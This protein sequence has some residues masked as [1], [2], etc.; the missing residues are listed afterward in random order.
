MWWKFGAAKYLAI[1]TWFIEL[2]RKRGSNG[3]FYCCKG[4]IPFSGIVIEGI[5]KVFMVSIGTL[6]LKFMHVICQ[7]FISASSFVYNSNC[8]LTASTVC[9]KSYT[10]VYFYLLR[11][12]MTIVQWFPNFFS[13]WHTRKI[14]KCLRHAYKRKKVALKKLFSR[15]NEVAITL[16]NRQCHNWFHRHMS[17]LI[18]YWSN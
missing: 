11:L 12:F 6:F 5:I 13:L 10:N 7:N 8:K 16:F 4:R 15:I 18:S 3:V 17:L 14:K 9:T 2:Y 1:L